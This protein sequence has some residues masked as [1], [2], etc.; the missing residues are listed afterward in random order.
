[1]ACL[2]LFIALIWVSNPLT[3]APLFFFTY[4]F[5]TWILD[6]PHHHVQIELT[7]HWVTTEL[8]NIWAPLLTG[9]LLTGLFCGCLGYTGI[10]VFWRWQVTRNWLNRKKARAARKKAKLNQS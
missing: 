1:L 9:S 4:K 10:Q 5:G 2:S 3:I 8:T 7:W 6:R